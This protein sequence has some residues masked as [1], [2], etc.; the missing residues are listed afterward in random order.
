MAGE[1]SVTSLGYWGAYPGAEAATSAFLL[2]CDDTRVLIDCGSGVLMKLQSYLRPEELD[3]V[4]ITHYHADHT[5]DLGCLQYALRVAE[6]LGNRSG[7]LP[8]YGHDE[9]VSCENMTY[10][11]HTIFRRY[12]ENSP[13]S[14]GPLTFTFFKAN[15]TE[16]SYAVRAAWGDRVIVFSGDTAYSHTMVRAADQADVFFC[17]CSLYNAFTGMVEGHLTAGE[18]GIIARKAGVK[19]L[20]LTHLPHYGNHA[21]LL[22][23]AGE[24]FSGPL[25]LNEAGLVWRVT[26]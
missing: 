19:E 12:S 18:A 13:L 25:R 15:H 8:I 10:R 7:P 26:T 6:S 16:P 3:A 11:T 5:A 1:L 9:D 23:E 17:E 4:I 20:V 24:E 2:E 21:D 14:L 22:Q